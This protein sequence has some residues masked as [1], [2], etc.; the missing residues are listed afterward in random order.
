MI[1]RIDKAETEPG[2]SGL[3]KNQTCPSKQFDNIFSNNS[4]EKTEVSDAMKQGYASYF[5][6]NMQPL[7]QELQKKSKILKNH[8]FSIDEKMKD[9]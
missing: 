7:V 8:K 6:Q 1:D 2:I 5:D 9:L 3:I 4:E